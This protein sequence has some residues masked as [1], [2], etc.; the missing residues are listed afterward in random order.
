MNVRVYKI[1]GNVVDDPQRLERFCEEFAQLEGP[2]ILVHGGGVMADKVQKALG[3]EPIRIQGRR[4]TDAETL[5]VVTMVYSGQCNKVVTSK[6]QKYGVN[7]IGLSG[8]DGNILMANRRAPLLIEGES[9]DFG[10]VGDVTPDSVNVELMD[11]LLGNG[12]VPVLCAI[13][14][15]GKG[16]LL[17]TNADTVASSIASALKAELVVCFEKNGV[18]SDKENPDSVIP[19]IDR[20]SF[21]RMKADGTVADGMIPK[22]TNAFKAIEQGALKV[23]IR[24]SDNLLQEGGTV[25]L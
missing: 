16:Q 7:S 15:D 2:R 13:N 23:T 5:T 11:L 21:E 19:S 25:I 20:E 22:L 17:N 9:V 12:L 3:I 10:F 8:C 4:V 18:L 24:N 6:L 1:G 14:H